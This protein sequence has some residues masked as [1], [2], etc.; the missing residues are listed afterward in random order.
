[1]PAPGGVLGRSCAEHISLPAS[2]P[3]LAYASIR[4]AVAATL[5]LMAAP[6]G[7]LGYLSIWG[8]CAA[9][10]ASIPAGRVLSVDAASLPASF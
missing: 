10:L 2:L 6:G 8:V 9:T 1:M 7:G 3:G 4:G 5:A